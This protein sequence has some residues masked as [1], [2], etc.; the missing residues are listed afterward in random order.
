MKTITSLLI[1]CFIFLTGITMS[2]AQCD[3]NNDIIQDTGTASI[4]APVVIGQYISAS[5]S[6]EI[7]EISIFTST[8]LA[9]RNVQMTVYRGVVVST[10][11]LPPVIGSQTVT[12]NPSR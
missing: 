6:G 11:N 3:S 4:D 5:C 2:Y 10:T 12:M 9:T 1:T 8:V 7:G